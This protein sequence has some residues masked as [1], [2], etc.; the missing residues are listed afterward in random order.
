VLV[1]GRTSTIQQPPQQK[2][3]MEHRE[4]ILRQKQSAES[5]KYTPTVALVWLLYCV[6]GHRLVRSTL[7]SPVFQC[8]AREHTSSKPALFGGTRIISVGK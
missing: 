4:S 7:H 5:V 6:T 3:T 2:Q 8:D 1:I